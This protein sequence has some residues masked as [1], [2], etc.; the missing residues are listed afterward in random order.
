MIYLVLPAYNEEKNLVKIF[1]KINNLSISKKFTV[2]LIDDC[3]IDKT[4]LI[5]KK[6]KRFKLIYKKHLKNKGL[7]IAL[8]SGF[9]I[10]K[11]KLKKDDLV[12]TMDSDNTHP[13]KIIPNMLLQLKKTNADIVIASRFLPRSQVNG[14]GFFREYLS[15]LAKHVFSFFFPYKNLKEY[16][17]NFRIYKSFLIKELIKNKYFFK[18]EDFNIAVKII[19][20]LIKKFH[21]IKIL[22][23]PLVLNYHYKIG[24][25]KMKVFKNILLTLNLIFFRKF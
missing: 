19:L 16:T 24:S 15:V 8:E 5:V 17:C 11:K 2:I 12:I 21:N 14:L 10:L 6:K 25:S 1:N 22:E 13:I 7:S 4:H 3:S 23:Y 9:N 18:G 20:Y